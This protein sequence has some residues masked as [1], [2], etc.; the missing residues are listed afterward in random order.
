MAD[1]CLYLCFLQLRQLCQRWE[2]NFKEE[3]FTLFL[4]SDASAQGYLVP[5]LWASLTQ[6]IMVM[7]EEMFPSRWQGTEEAWG[8]GQ[9][10]VH[11]QS[12]TW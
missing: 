10:Q 7:G 3:M 11:S 8:N 9:G 12:S 5:L 6:G 2:N 4:I 1:V